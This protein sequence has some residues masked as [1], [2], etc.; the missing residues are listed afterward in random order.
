MLGLLFSFVL[1]FL[2]FF[3]CLPKEKPQTTTKSTNSQNQYIWLSIHSS[4]ADRASGY[5]VND[6]SCE[7]ELTHLA[8]L[9][10]QAKPA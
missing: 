7:R 9:S 5:S 10:S 8:H 2:S 4:E 1:F 3:L 6:S